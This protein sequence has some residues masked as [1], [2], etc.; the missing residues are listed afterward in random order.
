MS[1]ARPLVAVIGPTASGKSHLSI[2]LANEFSGEI[3]NCD[4]LQMYRW[5]DIGTGKPDAEERNRVPHHL[6]DVLDPRQRF[7]AGE[8]A[9]MARKTIS[10]IS[11]RENLPFVVGGTGF[12]LRAL[13]DGLF[14]GPQRN[15]ALRERLQARSDEKGRGYLHRILARM[16]PPS[17]ARIHPNDTPKIIRAIEVS[18]ESRRPMS[19]MFEQGR[20]ALEGYR[21][22]KLG[23]MPPRDALNE[24]INRRARSMFESGL[25]AEVQEILQRGVPKTAPPFES[26]GYRE[27][28]AC[29]SGEL[30]EEQ[31]IE[32]TQIRTRQ[33]AKRQLTWFRKEADVEWLHGF[34]ADRG[35]LDQARNLVAK[36]LASA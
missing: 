23:L 5:F 10:D 1:A 33:Y 32:L 31:S 7:A 36:H 3:V 14:A 2:D 11:A 28:L 12:Y 35:I 30:T 19:Q 17:A 26:V 8:Y 16:D 22:L 18:V 29:L 9:R 13:V 34:G 21:V 6:I 27:A 15:T 24:A 20:Q 25:V 4:S